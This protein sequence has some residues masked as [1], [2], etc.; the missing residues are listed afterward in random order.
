MAYNNPMMRV[1]QPPLDPMTGLP[2][3]DV[4]M[5]PPRY[6]QQ[7]VQNMAGTPEM[8]QYG[9]AGMSAPLFAKGTPL[10]GNAFSAALQAA[11]NSGQEMFTVGDKTY[12]VK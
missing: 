1:G 10:H 7:E 12:N 6:S 8:R 5:V 9:A 3:E 2:V 4:T 11:K